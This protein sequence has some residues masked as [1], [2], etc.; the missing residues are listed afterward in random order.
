VK[1]K[2]LKIAF[3]DDEKRIYSIDQGTPEEI[4]EGLKELSDELVKRHSK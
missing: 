2:K 4:A 3:V 1:G